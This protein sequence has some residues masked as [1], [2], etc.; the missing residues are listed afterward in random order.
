MPTYPVYFQ[1]LSF[2]QNSPILSGMEAANQIR[3]QNIANQL[4]NVQLQ[5]APQMSQAELSLKQAQLPYMQAQTGLVNAQTGAIP[6]EIQERLAQAGLLGSETA[7][8]RFMLSNPGL[9]MP[10]MAGQLAA[11]QWMQK[12]NPDAFNSLGGGQQTGAMTPAQDANTIPS[13]IK[14]PSADQVGSS[15]VSPA[16]APSQPMT[17]QAFQPNGMMN[18][19]TP[20]NNLANTIMQSTL[21]P[22]QRQLAQSNYYN[23]R[24]MPYVNLPPDAKNQVI[25]QAT[26]FGYTPDEAAADFLKGSSLT[27]LAKNKGFDSDPTNWPAPDYSP[28]SANRTLYQRR[29]SAL[30]EINA[31]NP[32]LTQSLAPYS[33]RVAGF[34]PAQIAGAISNSDPDQQA[35]FLAAKALMPEMAAL[36][37]KVM[38][39]Q[40]GIEAIREVNNASMGNIKSFQSLVNPDVYTKANKYMDQWLSQ[41]TGAANKIMTSGKPGAGTEQKSDNSD[42]LGIR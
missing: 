4:A 22:I 16:L 18:T 30:A 32:I 40:V 11:I 23:M 33:Q 12:N 24:T 39:G 2:Q 25:A 10:G 1:P 31:L 36:R 35:K 21:A 14:L 8:N 27:D 5:Y 20:A 7:K 37:L 9:M 19:Q 38:Q 34:S 42:P 3:G 17:G 6:S 26:S 13:A 41:A 15:V 29:N 28:T